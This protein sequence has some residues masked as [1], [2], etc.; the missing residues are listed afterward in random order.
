M[1]LALTAAIPLAALALFS[2]LATGATPLERNLVG[3]WDI[4]RDGCQSGYLEYRADGG[5]GQIYRRDAS[6][7]II[8]PL[9]GNGTYY[10]VGDSLFTEEGKLDGSIRIESRQRLHFAGPDRMEVDYLRMVWIDDVAHT[11]KPVE[12][13]SESWSRCPAGVLDDV[14]PIAAYTDLDP[15]LVVGR[16]GWERGCA[17]GYVEYTQ[18][19]L[20]RLVEEAHEDE[21]DTFDYGFYE[22]RERTLLEVYVYDSGIWKSESNFAFDD[23]GRLF[24]SDGMNATWSDT[25]GVTEDADPFFEALFNCAAD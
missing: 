19:G 3:A 17:S 9:W 5:F 8:D 2:G 21:G 7:W 4:Y 1:R 18:D 13:F 20:I 24:F 12:S 16:W 14:T 10:V 23:Q 11:A 6:Q 25:S 15:E 22:I